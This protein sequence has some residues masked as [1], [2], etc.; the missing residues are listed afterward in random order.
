MLLKLFFNLTILLLQGGTD[1]TD[2]NASS[3]EVKPRCM[4]LSLDSLQ[5]PFDSKNEITN[6]DGTDLHCNDGCFQ[7]KSF[8]LLKVKPQAAHL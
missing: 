8:S 6:F 2:E 5:N 7:V 4:C 1:S 3:G